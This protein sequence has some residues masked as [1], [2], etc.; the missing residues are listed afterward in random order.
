MVSITGYHTCKTEG[1][2]SYIRAMAP[3]LSESNERQ[4]LTQGFYFWTDT[5]RYA[6]HWGKNYPSGYAIVKC[7]LEI[8]DHLLLDLVGSGVDLDYFESRMSKYKSRLI[9]AGRSEKEC[10]VSTCIAWMRKIAKQQ[11]EFF[12]YVAI[13]AHDIPK[14]DHFPYRVG[15]KESMPIRTRQQLCLFDSAVSCI[16]EKKIVYPDDYASRSGLVALVKK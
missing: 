5:V 16:V 2:W 12:P 8:E 15:K 11:N 4:W 14:V 3:F 9:Q 7:K 13:K 1:G 10:T 6:H